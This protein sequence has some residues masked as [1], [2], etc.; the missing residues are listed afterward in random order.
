MRK[1]KLY[2]KDVRKAFCKIIK[3][4]SLKELKIARNWIEIKDSEFD[5]EAKLKLLDEEIKRKEKKLLE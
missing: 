4:F 3:N 2:K 5:R 1:G